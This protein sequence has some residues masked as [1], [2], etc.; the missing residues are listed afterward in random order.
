MHVAGA[1]HVE[2]AIIRAKARI[3][4]FAINEVAYLKAVQRELEHA[5]TDAGDAIALIVN[6]TISSIARSVAQFGSELD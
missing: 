3:G 5:N 2:Q 6:T 1:V 4:E